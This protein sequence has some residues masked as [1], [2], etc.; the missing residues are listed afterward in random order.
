M[1][2]I[3][4][5]LLSYT[6]IYNST[7]IFTLQAGAQRI[8][9]ASLDNSVHRTFFPKHF[10]KI[11][12]QIIR[13]FECSEMSAIF[14][15]GQELKISNR[16]HPT[17]RNHS[18]VFWEDRYPQ[19]HIWHIWSKEITPLGG[20]V[21]DPNARSRARTRKPVDGDPCQDF[22]VC[23]WVTVRPVDKLFVYPSE[24]ARR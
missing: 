23:P 19:W 21:I 9:I 15:L 16:L 17:S 14:V 7:F 20:F 6:G 13:P 22:I 18:Q 2:I 4:R 3:C 8:S 10:P 5:N 12:N 1:R 24:K 11:T